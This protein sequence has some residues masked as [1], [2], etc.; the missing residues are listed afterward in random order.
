MPLTDTAIRNLKSTGKPTKHSDSGGLHIL[1]SAQGA[2]LWKMAYR[3]NGK[4]KTLSFGIYPAVTLAQAR[5][6]RDQAK[7]AIALGIDPSEQVR[8]EKALTR[9]N[10]QNTFGVIAEEYLEKSRKEGIADVTLNKKRWILSLCESQLAH[11]PIDEISATD[12]L[13]PLKV[14][15]A[16]G[17]YET[18]R[19]LRAT[20]GQVFRYAIATARVDND[21]TFGLKGAL[22]TPTVSHRAAFTERGDFAG[23]LKSIWQYEGMPETIAGLKLMAYLY[24]RPGELRQ[25]EWKEFDLEA[26]MWS[27]PAAR[28][29]MRR[30]HKK[31]LSEAA[32]D[33]LRDLYQITGHRDLVFPSY[34]SPRRPMS[35][36][37]LNQAL[38]RMGYD[39]TQV[40]AHGFRASASSLLNESSKWNPDAIEAELAHAGTD[41]VRKAY[42]R[43]AYWDERVK[44]CEW[45]SQNIGEMF[46]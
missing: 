3:F 27:I 24:P 44:M 14:I 38:R 4:Q 35:E 12:V 34:Q 18:A 6:K 41:E 42:H 9:L 20:I 21:P 45:W 22:I 11:R 28:M 33:V 25:A 37:T 19:R 40:T 39:K 8:Q 23:L 26:K 16:K 32:V 15:E 5:K 36:N 1:L 46:N 30:P 2:K 17:H 43:A 31:P 13:I 10:A 29:K 7:E